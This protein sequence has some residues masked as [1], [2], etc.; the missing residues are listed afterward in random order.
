MHR[1]FML[2]LN[3]FLLGFRIVLF[4]KFPLVIHRLVNVND[5]F[6]AMEL[7]VVIV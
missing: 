6:E 2:D 4:L 1:R 3:I 5:V 7:F